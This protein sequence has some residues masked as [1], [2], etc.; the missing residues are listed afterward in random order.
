MKKGITANPNLFALVQLYQVRVKVLDAQ[1]KLHDNRTRRHQTR[2]AELGVEVVVVEVECGYHSSEYEA[3][4]E[5][6]GDHDRIAEDV[7]EAEAEQG[8]KIDNH[9]G[10]CERVY[11]LF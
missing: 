10:H 4:D 2:K 5:F 9:E 11:E 7:R 6:D 3:I 8:E 1:Q